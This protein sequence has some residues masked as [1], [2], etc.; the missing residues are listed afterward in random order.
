MVG[1]GSFEDLTAQY[2]DGHLV[3]LMGADSIVLVGTSSAVLDDGDF[4]WV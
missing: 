4:I 3:I 1:Y 2:N